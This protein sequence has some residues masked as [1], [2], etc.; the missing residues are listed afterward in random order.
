MDSYIKMPL[1]EY[2][3]LIRLSN[4]VTQRDYTLVNYQNVC[5]YVYTNDLVLKNIIKEKERI[6]EENRQLEEELNKLEK[7]NL[8][9]RVFNI[10]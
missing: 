1:E 2:Q 6:E 7:R 3:E 4:Q 8:F 10:E 5:Y 9:K